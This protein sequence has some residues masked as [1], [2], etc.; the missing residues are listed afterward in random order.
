MTEGETHRERQEE[1]QRGRDR[2]RDREKENSGVSHKTGRTTKLLFITRSFG[3][4]HVYIVTYVL[5]IG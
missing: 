5:I 4:S 1:R 3:Q 2:A